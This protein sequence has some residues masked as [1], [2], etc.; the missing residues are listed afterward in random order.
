M[1]LHLFFFFVC[2]SNLSM[3]LLILLL[4][5]LMLGSFPGV[6]GVVMD[7]DAWVGISDFECSSMWSELLMKP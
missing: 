1:L 3:F 4:L 2:E 6:V 5:S 7:M